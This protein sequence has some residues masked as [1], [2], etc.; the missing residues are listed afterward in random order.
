MGHAF[1]EA[2]VQ[3]LEFGE[4][5]RLYGDGALV[6]LKGMLEAGISYF[7]G[8]PGAPTSNLID[9]AADAY[10]AVLKPPRYLHGIVGQ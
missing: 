2:D 7:G 5:Q 1:S 3:Q 8:Y 4:G 9:A 10:E 6:V